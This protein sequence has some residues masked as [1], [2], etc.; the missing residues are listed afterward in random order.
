M[1]ARRQSGK[2]I[3]RPPDIGDMQ[4]TRLVGH[5][6]RVLALGGVT[7]GLT[8]V[9]VQQGCRLVV[10][11]E[12]PGSAAV[13]G[14]AVRTIVG[15]LD[16][17]DLA[18]ELR[19]EL[20]DVVIAANVLER[21]QRPERILAQSLHLLDDQGTMFVALRN[22]AHAA[23]RLALLDG[24]LPFAE[25]GGLARPPLH[26]FTA[27]A[28]EE[29]LVSLGLEIIDVE[30]I[31]ASLPPA[32]G[33]LDIEK[34]PQGVAEWAAAQPEAL[35]Y[36]FIFHCRSREAPRKS[37]AGGTDDVAVQGMSGDE[38]LVQLQATA[39][40]RLDGAVRTLASDNEKLSTE[41]D[42][43]ATERHALAT[44]RDALATE[45]DALAIDRDAVTSN[46]LTQATALAAADSV[47][48]IY[49]KSR[50]VRMATALRRIEV[51]I[52]NRLR[53]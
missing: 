51:G 11:G 43:L 10:V 41:R 12:D 4:L 48:R 40:A 8:K 30:R 6:A 31:S 27:G 28:A 35:T 5:G 17:L 53:S 45:R 18:T 19:G 13:A 47:I 25:G 33:S 9:L 34:L 44:E 32:L 14:V 22:V 38:Q 7:S 46:L 29:L 26:F 37:N 15:D 42:A 16:T 21:A 36:E 1:N 20:F 52:R 24:R 2:G 49:Q 50:A 3:A 39:L 23:A